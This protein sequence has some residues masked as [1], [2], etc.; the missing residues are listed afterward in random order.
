MPATTDGGGRGRR[1]ARLRSGSEDRR[2]HRRGEPRLEES[3]VSWLVGEL[4][5][6]DDAVPVVVDADHAV[7]DEFD[8]AAGV[9]PAGTARGGPRRQTRRCPARWLP[10]RGRPF[11]RRCADPRRAGPGRRP[12]WRVRGRAGRSS[13]RCRPGCPSS[14]T[15]P[16][17][18]WCGM[19]SGR[20]RSTAVSD[21]GP[22]VVLAGVAG[23]VLSVDGHRDPCA[24]SR[25]GCASPDQSSPA[26]GLGRPRGV[27]GPGPVPAD[28]SA[29]VSPCHTRNVA[30]VASPPGGREVAS[31][32]ATGPATH[33][34]RVRPSSYAGPGGRN[35]PDMLEIGNS[36]SATEDRAEFS[37][38]AEMAAPLIAGTNTAGA[39]ATTVSILSDKAVIAVDQDSLGKQGRMGSSAGGHNVLA[40]SDVAWCCSTRPDPTRPSAPPPPPRSARPQPPATGSPTCGRARSPPPAARS[41]RR[42]RPTAS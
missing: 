11:R 34:R 25:G 18:L 40:N 35:D 3:R 2:S 42:C 22:G 16:G 24:P 28:V 41:P 36:M 30:A 4:E 38:W 5:A 10:C 26:T 14:P 32:Q 23:E 13:R 15:S 6:V 17:G 1:S 9:D 20:G 31:A 19:I 8:V 7:G 37:L 39:S 27:H 12:V 21:L 29:A 33:Q